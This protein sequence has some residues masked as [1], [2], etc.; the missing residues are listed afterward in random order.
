MMSS[1]KYDVYQQCCPARLF[2]ATIADKW[3]LLI[4]NKLTQESQHFNG[5]KNS[6]QG[7]SSKVLSQKLKMLER[8][9]FILR[10][11]LDTAPI[12]VEYSLTALGRGLAEM[13]HQFK[14]W[15]EKN[16]E[17]VMNAQHEYDL[18]LED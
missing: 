16:I 18:Q 12:R 11:V 4:L 6:V 15:S 1:L 5:L 17:L 2:F 9:G 13:A 10:R 8:D 14:E 7:I 3:V